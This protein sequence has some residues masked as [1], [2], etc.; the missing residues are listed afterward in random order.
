MNT[1]I[2]WHWARN[3]PFLSSLYLFEN[4]GVLIYRTALAVYL[5]ANRI[6]VRYIWF[7]WDMSTVTHAGR[8]WN[9]FEFYAKSKRCTQIAVLSDQWDRHV[10]EIRI[11]CSRDRH[12]TQIYPLSHIRKRRIQTIQSRIYLFPILNTPIDN[13]HMVKVTTKQRKTRYGCNEYHA[14]RRR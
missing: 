12:R 7:I 8:P 1:S 6:C 14:E 5:Y 11:D 2:W 4:P 3:L 13:K 9:G 10:F